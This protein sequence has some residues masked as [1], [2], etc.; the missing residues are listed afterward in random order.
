M[1]IT[2]ENGPSGGRYIA[3]LEGAEAEMTFSRDVAHAHHYRSY[4]RT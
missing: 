2:E 4:R 3:R 1:Q